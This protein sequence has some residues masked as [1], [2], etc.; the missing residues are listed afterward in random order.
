MPKFT[1]RYGKKEKV[2]KTRIQVF[3]SN[4]VMKGIGTRTIYGI[5]A[6][7]VLKD[8]DAFLETKYGTA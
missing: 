2:V 6:D 8:L 4:G 3:K 1:K 7:V 5:S